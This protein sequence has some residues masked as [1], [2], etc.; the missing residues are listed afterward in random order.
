M[1][2]KPL[3]FVISVSIA[4]LFVLRG[5]LEP[6]GLSEKSTAAL[7]LTT[8]KF[9]W[10]YLLVT[11]GFLLFALFLAFSRYG[12]I[13]LGNDIDRPAYSKTSWFAMLFSA[14]MGIGLVFYGMAE[15]ISHYMDP[16]P[17]IAP[18]T[19]QAAR[20]AMRY[21]FFHY[22][23]HAWGIYT[24]MGLALAYF[25]FRKKSSSLISSTFYPLLGRR[26]S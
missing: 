19:P 22:G 20:V 2:Q 26:V 25:S 9:G 15:P 11:F 5:I 23:L 6:H 1:K 7:K 18:Q 8:E 17:G 21:T 24:V 14:G 4:L 3:V 16:P 10:F 12:N 13:R